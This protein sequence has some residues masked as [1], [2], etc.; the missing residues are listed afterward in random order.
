VAVIP[1]ASGE[2]AFCDVSG[3]TDTESYGD[4][5][6]KWA[7]VYLISQKNGEGDCVVDIQLTLFDGT[8]YSGTCSPSSSGYGELTIPADEIFGTHTITGTNGLSATVT[9]S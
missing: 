6:C 2:T 4:M 9:F 5:Q 8:F 3:E 7:D 1:I